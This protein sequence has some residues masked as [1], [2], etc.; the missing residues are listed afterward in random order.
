MPDR[1]D[2]NGRPPPR[3][4]RSGSAEQWQEQR[5]VH[6][7]EFGQAVYPPRD[8]VDELHHGPGEGLPEVSESP[9]RRVEEDGDI[10]KKVQ[11][12]AGQA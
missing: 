7:P 11:D 4:R 10:Y 5:S 6:G 1:G 3:M 2:D 12:D 9:G 8:G